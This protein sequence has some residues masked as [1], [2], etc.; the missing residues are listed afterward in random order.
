MY[1]TNFHCHTAFCDGEGSPEAFVLSALSREVRVL[2]F[3]SHIAGPEDE[4]SLKAERIDEYLAE[5]H[6][7]RTRYMDEIDIYAG[8][9]I[10]YVPGVSW[11][12]SLGAPLR[13]MDFLVGA[14]HSV[15]QFASGKPWLPGS[16]RLE[17]QQGLEH[18]FT[19]DIHAAVKRYYELIRWMIMLENPDVIAHLDLIKLHN[20]GN[21]YFDETEDWY[22]Q[23]IM[24]TLKVIANMGSVVE[25]NTRGLYT[26]QC[27][28]LYPSQWILEHMLALGIPVTLS[29]DAHKPEELTAG[30]SF[31]AQILKNIGYGYL[32]VMQRGEWVDVR[33]DEHGVHLPGGGLRAQTA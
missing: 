10:S 18:I 16:N 19:G 30:F 21:A 6:R 11:W 4:L 13:Q 25:V 3:S 33:F 29:S 5:V 1:W 27:L 14:V 9:E 17:F 8:A 24:K 20:A 28:D 22:R 2:G 7:L 31:A 12:D 26:G 15:D 32:T 23:E